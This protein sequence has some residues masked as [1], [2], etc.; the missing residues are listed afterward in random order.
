MTVRGFFLPEE[1]MLTGEFSM[2]NIKHTINN[3]YTLIYKSSAMHDLFCRVKEAHN[4][5]YPVL[6]TGETGT[7]KELI[8][9]I[10]HDDK[11]KPFP[12]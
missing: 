3:K 8:A 9:Q 7:G 11:A 6:I 12:L 10:L 4:L 5:P 1:E 2:K